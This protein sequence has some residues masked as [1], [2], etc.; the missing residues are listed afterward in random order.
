MEE[1]S[2]SGAGPGSGPR[3][4]S[5]IPSP[6]LLEPTEKPFRWFTRTVLQ[7]VCIQGCGWGG[8]GGCVIMETGLCSN[9]VW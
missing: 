3:Q 5:P 2:Q 7:G 6:L 9:Q 8:R 4:R 1:L